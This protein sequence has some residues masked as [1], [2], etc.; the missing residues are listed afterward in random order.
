[1]PV[2]QGF[3][4]FDSRHKKG[5]SRYRG[6]AGSI[7]GSKGYRR[8]H[9]RYIRYGRICKEAAATGGAATL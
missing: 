4:R 3:S 6:T 8:F 9:A 7:L 1:M 5:F 2:T